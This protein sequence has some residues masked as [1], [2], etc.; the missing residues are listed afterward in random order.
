MVDIN[1]NSSETGN[2]ELTA[3]GDSAT[4][5]IQEAPET[6]AKDGQPS[7]KKAEKSVKAKAAPSPVNGFLDKVKAMINPEAAS[8]VS[9]KPKK[10]AK[11][12]PANTKKAGNEGEQVSSIDIQT[13]ED[14]DTD[15]ED[16]QNS[17][18]KGEPL[19]TVITRNSFYRDSYRNLVRVAIAEA[20][21]ISLLII[22]IISYMG[23]SKSE[24]RYFAT[25]ADGRIMKMIPLNRANKTTSALMSWVARS[26]T[27]IMTFGFHDYQT[28]L[29][30][31]SRYFTRRG[32]EGFTKALQHSKIIEAVEASSQV[33]TCKP[34]S[35]PILVEEGVFNG[36]YR[37][38]VDLPLK[39]NYQSSKKSRSDNLNVRMVIDRVTSLE[40]PDGVGIEQWIAKAN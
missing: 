39:V 21:V 29:Q 8:A 6:V 22:A 27:E 28:R 1:E 5:V 37:W 3:E 14:L 17:E 13:K 33:V 11:A 35:A 7:E 15:A 24:D 30:K 10:S 25:T 18:Y 34:R 31:S 26:A 2:P 16:N 32:W 12:K 36:R 40:N 20:V 38:V 4:E 23:V 19:M 9:V